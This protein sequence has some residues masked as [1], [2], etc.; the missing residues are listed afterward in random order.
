MTDEQHTGPL[1]GAGEAEPAANPASS[2]PDSSGPAPSG[3][4]NNSASKWD[5]YFADLPEFA[6]SPAFPGAASDEPGDAEA[7]EVESATEAPRTDIRAAGRSEAGVD[8]APS[9]VDRADPAD[10]APDGQ[11]PLPL[12]P[13]LLF[14]PSE[15]EPDDNEGADQ[16]ASA[17]VPRPLFGA[18]PPPP[19]G[20]PAGGGNGRWE[21]MFADLS[22][23]AAPAPPVREP[24]VSSEP[25]HDPVETP[26][27]DFPLSIRPAAQLPPATP[28]PPLEFEDAPAPGAP[29]DEPP[30]ELVAAESGR[31]LSFERSASTNGAGTGVEELRPPP[32]PAWVVALKDGPSAVETGSAWRNVFGDQGRGEQPGWQMAASSAGGAATLALP[33]VRVRS[34]A[35]SSRWGALVRGAVEALEVLALALLMFVAVRSIA[36]NFV[37]DGGSMEPTFANGEMLI[38]NK[39]AYRTFNVSWL[40][41]TDQQHWQPFGRPRAGDIVVFRF[42][43]NPERDFIKR[44]IATQGQTVE[45][46]SGVL[47][48]DGVPVQEPY[49]S[50]PVAYEFG[51]IT[52]PEGSMFVLGDNRNNS[53]DSHSWGTLEQQ[54][55]IGRAELRYWPLSRAG[56][57]DHSAASET[58]AASAGVA[59]SPSI[60]R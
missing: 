50:Q 9:P 53:Y 43:Q 60:A 33:G 40:P 44:I 19:S 16:E 8:E 31:V 47:M 26:A 38:V 32:P 10:D 25:R 30:R 22:E 21:R 52:V 15:P 37:V 29:D 13:R 11:A 4:S 20:H 54:Y 23:L 12:R 57:M 39:L 35:H 36:Q 7:A 5:R 14:P 18:V 34:A 45:V 28:A 56:R 58:P 17:S 1:P 6:P 24:I 42:P 27:P 49:L 3:A 41:W 46:R 48:I 55:L 2:G 51:P 59:L